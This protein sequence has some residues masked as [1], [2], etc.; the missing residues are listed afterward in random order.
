MLC[1]VQNNEDKRRVTLGDR[2]MQAWTAQP[3]CA[4]RAAGGAGYFL[5]LVPG[6]ASEWCTA[7]KCPVRL[8]TCTLLNLH[9]YC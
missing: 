7:K 9:R 4:G 3:L 2:G 1:C 6:G 8:D 5:D